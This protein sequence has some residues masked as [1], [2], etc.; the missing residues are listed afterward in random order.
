MPPALAH[1]I[2]HQ[3]PCREA[4]VASHSATSVICGRDRRPPQVAA[5][6]GRVAAVHLDT[7]GATAA[8]GRND[9]V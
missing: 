8:A 4:S 3:L 1:L 5:A 9:R 7:S 6:A 2:Q